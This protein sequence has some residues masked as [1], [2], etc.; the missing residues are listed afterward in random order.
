MNS[1]RLKPVSQISFLKF[2]S[3]LFLIVAIWNMGALTYA[4]LAY[5]LNFDQSLFSSSFGDYY[6]SDLFYVLVQG[7]F[8][9]PYE[10]HPEIPT[11]S[12]NAYLPLP[13]LLIEIFDITVI[14]FNQN[15]GIVWIYVFFLIIPTLFLLYKMMK[16]STFKLRISVILG[17]GLLSPPMMYIF[18]TAN[19][20][21]F[22]TFT[23]LAS[24]F[25]FHEKNRKNI[26]NL[27]VSSAII[28]STKPQYLLSNFQQALESRRNLYS[29]I[30]GSM[31]GV[32]VA[33]TGFFYF[34]TSFSSNIA[35]WSKSLT[36]F[37]DVQPAYLVHNNASIFGNLGALE[38]WLFPDNLNQL[39]LTKYQTLII[40]LLLLVVLGTIFLLWRTSSFKW[41]SLWLVISIP[42]YLTPVS[43]TYNLSLFLI[44]L[45]ILFASPREKEDFSLTVLTNRVNSSVFVVL[46]FLTFATKPVRIWL[47]KDAADTNLFNTMNAF[48]LWFAIFLAYRVV[49][50]AKTLSLKKN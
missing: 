12:V 2:M 18:T 22:V 41:L 7:N 31:I 50:S 48:S 1:S 10:F 27:L 8:Q 46:I 21:G 42:V 33:V 37:V 45:A 9:N 38:L 17:I 28:L 14:D 16:D 39:F 20:Q 32:G 26:R 4:I 19:I 29:T 47:V 23:L 3:R 40:G 30:L 34:G 43:F 11:L 15:S 44:P 36:Q 35:Y 25:Y 6:R 24:Y 13:Y 5:S 49:K